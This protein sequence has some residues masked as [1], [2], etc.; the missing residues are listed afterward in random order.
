M[1]IKFKQANS[2]EELGQILEL[3]KENLRGSIP[4]REQQR[5]G[6]VTV[7]HTLNQLRQMN[8]VCGHIL[9][10]DGP[11]LAGYALCMHPTFS[12]DIVVLRPMFVQLEKW[13]PAS[14]RYMVMGQ[15]CIRK[16]YRG[17]GVFRGLYTHMKEVL[18]PEYDSIVTEVDRTN[19]RSLDAHRA[20]GFLPL[21]TYASG[22]QDWEVILLPVGEKESA[23]RVG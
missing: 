4:R 8:K 14:A 12:R 11:V 6:F 13:L 9:A 23:S 1:H 22:G 21:C 17:K 2:G 10:K 7:K 19:T 3:Q 20:M 18:T 15:I 16:E 5:E